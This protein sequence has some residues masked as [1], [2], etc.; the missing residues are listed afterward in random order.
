MID[1]EFLQLIGF[2]VVVNL[3]FWPVMVLFGRM[4]AQARAERANKAKRPKRAR[5][6]RRK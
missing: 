4:K 3:A 5:R 6:A 2:A 1:S